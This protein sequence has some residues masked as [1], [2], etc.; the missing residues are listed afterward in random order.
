MAKGGKHLAPSKRNAAR[1]RLKLYS[2]GA[3]SDKRRRVSS[4]T[5]QKN[6]LRAAAFLLLCIV[7]VSPIRGCNVGGDEY[8]GHA[9]AQKIAVEDA[10][11][12][13]EK[14]RDMSSD[15]IKLDGEFYYK[16]Q[17]TGSVTDYR[18][19]IDAES[20]EILTQVFYRLDKT[21]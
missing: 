15:M 18:Y 10:G 19:I 2:G 12:P 8:I 5:M 6:L 20:G 17:F 13:L 16:V 11:I 14:A 4:A 1:P 9:A 3:R 7:M 21:D